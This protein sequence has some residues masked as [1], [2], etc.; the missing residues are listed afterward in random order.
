MADIF[1]NAV[2]SIILGIEDFREGSDERMLSAAR[3]YYAGLLL[4]GKECL[5]RA[6]PEADPMEIIGA[7]FE[8]VPDGDGGVDH[9]VVGYATVDLEQLKS[10]FKKFSLPWPQ[11]NTKKLQQ[12]RNNIEH[13]HLAEPVG[14]LREAIASSF[15]MI[16]D[17][18]EILNED[19]QSTLAD[20]WDTIL[21]EKDAFDR[22]QKSC[23]DSL[24]HVNWPG[25]VRDLDQMSC[26]KCASSLIGQADR[27]NTDSDYI[28]GKCF[29]CGE[30]F[31]QQEIVEMVVATS[32]EIDSY[33]AA[34][35]GEGSPIAD[36]P[37]CGAATY[38][39]NGEASI[40]F[41]CKET[42]AGRCS[43]CGTAITVHEYN[44]EYPEL[45]GYCA[46]VLEKVMRE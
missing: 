1:D 10:R 7:K 4:L 17:F 27:E 19:P 32:Y 40:C 46:H 30:E 6:A 16:I 13:Y 38:V 14:S 11:T 37:E 39:E 26:P 25:E 18:F 5:V 28:K 2:A 8:P 29:Q 20:V 43:R 15:Q 21:E 41:S 22:V 9:E 24:L 3:N 42:V 33:L 36:C 34:K 45:C 23:V 35:N 31:N 44:P 12:F